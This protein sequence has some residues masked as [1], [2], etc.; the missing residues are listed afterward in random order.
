MKLAPAAL[1]AGVVATGMLAVR[2]ITRRRRQK[3]DAAAD[4]GAIGWGVGDDVT[5]A[6]SNV[7]PHESGAVKRPPQSAEP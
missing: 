5:Q 7:A 3:P 1:G 4:R 2:Y 6:V